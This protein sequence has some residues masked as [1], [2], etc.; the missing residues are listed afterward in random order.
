VHCAVKI[1]SQGVSDLS[2]VLL[3]NVGT[4]SPLTVKELPHMIMEQCV[5]GENISGVLYFICYILF[6][7]YFVFIPFSAVMM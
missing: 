6:H 4:P 5:G 3:C 1:A 2:D 7:K